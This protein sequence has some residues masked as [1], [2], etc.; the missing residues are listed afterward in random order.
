[1]EAKQIRNGDNA[2]LLLLALGED[3]GSKVMKGFSQAQ[4]KQI[5]RTMSQLN[6]IKDEDA[7][8]AISSFFVDYKKHSGIVGGSR[9]YVINMLN[10]TLNGNIAKDLVAD[11]YGDEL[12]LLAETLSWIPAKILSQSLQEEHVSMK[13]LL[14]AHLEPEYAEQVLQQLSEEECN[15]LLYQISKDQVISKTVSDQLKELIDKC[16]SD[17][18]AGGLQ[19]ING[20]KIAASIINRYSGDKG[21]LFNY[22]KAQDPSRADALQDALFDFNIIFTQEADVIVQL[23]EKVS[24]EL[25]AMALKGVD[26]AQ[27]EVVI[28]TFTTRIAEQLRDEIE[29][30]GSVS[31]VHVTKARNEI[32]DLI[33]SMQAS[34]D[35]VL[36]LGNEEKL[37]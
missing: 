20:T 32:L 21:N 35:L 17:Y 16:K 34:G 27:K 7:V 6:D 25:W 26:D 2:A 8:D 22:L 30:L 11:I 23:N 5:T 1:M 14:I 37:S 18:D 33:R 4:I 36:S 10:K 3:V 24:T 31:K 13:A 19:N 12:R 29:M 15:E 28:S 9:K